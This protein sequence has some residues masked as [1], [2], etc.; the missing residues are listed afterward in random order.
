MLDAFWRAVAYCIHPRVI[1]LSLVPLAVMVVAAFV[2]GYFFW[3]GAVASLATW[4][5]SRE[6]I[7]SALSWFGVTEASSMH[8]AVAKLLL[9][10]LVSPLVVMASLLL[11][12]MFMTPAMVD[13]V[14]E[15][16]FAEL[17][18]KRGGS[19]FVSVVWS[20]A[21]TAMAMLALLLSAP[22]WLIPPLI[23]VLPPLIWGWLTYRVFAFDA[24]A[25]HASQEERKAIMHKYRSTLLLMGILSG[26]L[27]A[28]PSLLWASGLT[29][30]ALAF[31]MVPLAIWVYTMVFALASLWFA[32]F[33][34][35]ALHRKRLEAGALPVAP[36]DMPVAESVPAKAAA[37]A[38]L[39][40]ASSAPPSKPEE[41]TV[42]AALED[43]RSSANDKG[44]GD[45]P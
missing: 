3:D 29:F 7:Q 28:A 41:P 17:E 15:R 33:C 8:A 2:F 32:H 31:V 13:L 30:V 14:G 16:R 23:L 42:P 4:I 12:A 26:F 36:P 40:E 24:L 35:D 44:E 38:P 27:G 19:F 18:K 34:L 25:T 6:W 37:S 11:V 1:G 43:G 9:L 22:L 39:M 10:V 45:K 20:V 5:E 21:S